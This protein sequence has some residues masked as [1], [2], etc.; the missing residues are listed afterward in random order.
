MVTLQKVIFHKSQ[1]LIT[2][3]VR[4]RPPIQNFNSYSFNFYG[5]LHVCNPCT[6]FCPWRVQSAGGEQCL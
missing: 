1:K 4:E 3:N 6:G 2:E 5:R